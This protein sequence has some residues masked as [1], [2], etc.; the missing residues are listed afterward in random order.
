MWKTILTQ[1]FATLLLMTLA[2]PASQAGDAPGRYSLTP[3]G[4]SLVRLDSHGRHVDL[5]VKGGELCLRSRLPT[6]LSR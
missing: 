5:R 2:A 3:V 6:T 4:G 1:A